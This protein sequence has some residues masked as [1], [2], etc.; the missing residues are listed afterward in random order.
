MAG[1]IAAYPDSDRQVADFISK[2]RKYVPEN[3]EVTGGV[4]LLAQNTT[5]PEQVRSYIKSYQHHGIGNMIFYNYGLAPLPFLK[6]LEEEY[7]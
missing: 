5:H 2:V 6:Q 3:M 7:L 4:R 1:V